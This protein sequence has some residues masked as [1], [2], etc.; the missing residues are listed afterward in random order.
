MISINNEY[1]IPINSD[2]SDFIFYKGTTVEVWQ[3]VFTGKVRIFKNNKI[4]NTRK[5]EGH[6]FD[7]KK[8]EQKRIE[9]QKQLE[10]LLRERD[11]RLKARAKHS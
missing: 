8:R 5:I 1:H 10:V 4:Y 11:E 6:R 3:D 7:P 9:E 2:G